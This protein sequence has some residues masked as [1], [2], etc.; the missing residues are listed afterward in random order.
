MGVIVFPS[1]SKLWCQ[2]LVSTSSQKCSCK[3]TKPQQLQHK[4]STFENVFDYGSNWLNTR[5]R[6]F[7]LVVIAWPRFIYNFVQELNPSPPLSSN[8]ARRNLDS[9]SN[10]LRPVGLMVTRAHW[11]AILHFLSSWRFH[12]ISSLSLSLVGPPSFKTK[13]E[14]RMPPCWNCPNPVAAPQISNV[15]G[16]ASWQL[17]WKSCS[18]K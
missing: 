7:C 5:E 13:K 3:I 18:K 1:C 14:C 11:M 12:V 10:L 15:Q 16:I 9:K 4:N 8:A 2:R 6:L 17:Q